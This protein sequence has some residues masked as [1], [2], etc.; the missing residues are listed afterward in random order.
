MASGM[1]AST[2]AAAL[3]STHP[4]P[5]TWSRSPASAA[6]MPRRMLALAASSAVDRFATVGLDGIASD[7]SGRRSPHLASVKPLDLVC[8]ALLDHAALELQ[9]RRHLP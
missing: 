3:S 1:S 8:E 5:A 6:G 7:A 2:S 9:R 4:T